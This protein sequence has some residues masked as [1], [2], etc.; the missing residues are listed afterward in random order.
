MV[1]SGQMPMSRTRSP[2]N[3]PARFDVLG[4]VSLAGPS[5]SSVPKILERASDNS[6]SVNIPC[7]S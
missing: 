6:S 5:A 4:H 2:H 7:S 3:R 1:T